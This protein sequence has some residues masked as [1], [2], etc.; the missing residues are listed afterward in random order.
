MKNLIIKLFS[1]VFLSKVFFA[2]LLTLSV[3]VA[4]N[5]E[6]DYQR[7]WERVLD[8]RGHWKFEIGDEQEWADPNYDDSDWDKLFVPAHWENE[9]FPGYDGFAWYRRSFNYENDFDEPNLYLRIGY[10]DDCDEV[11]FN[12]HL[13]GY[14]GI[15]PPNSQTAFP[16]ERIYYVPKD[17]LN[18]TGDNTIAVRVYDIYQAG[19]IAKGEIGLYLRN[20]FLKPDISLSGIWKFTT[21]DNLDW[22]AIDYPDNNWEN[23]HVPGLWANLGLKDY[24]GFGWYRTEFR[25]G[26]EF[27]DERLILLLGKID[28]LDEVYLNGKKIGKTGRIYSDPDRIYLDSDAYLENRAYTIPPKTLEFNTTNVI[29]VRVYDG[30][31]H[32]GIYD[33]PIG[34]VTQRHYVEWQRE[35]DRM[36]GVKDFFRTIFG[37]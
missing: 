25:L 20:S 14:R 28:D 32:G 13:I 30:L 24:D 22:Q 35:F 1:G 36:K 15:F 7:E 5:A 9:G 8:L 12:G 3:N 31:L 37:D 23:V 19:G 11:Y 34:I 33:G 29:A 27:K 21:G 6:D 17:Y 16:E 2:S 4:G 26:S 18:K 10:I